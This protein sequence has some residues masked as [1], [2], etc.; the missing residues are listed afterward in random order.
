MTVCRSPSLMLLMSRPVVPVLSACAPSQQMSTLLASLSNNSKAVPVV[1]SDDF[2]SNVIVTS[3]G[4]AVKEKKYSISSPFN[5]P[6]ISSDL[7]RV[8]WSRFVDCAKAVPVAPTISS[9][10]KINNKLLFILNLLLFWKSASFF[11]AQVGNEWLRQR[12]SWWLIAIINRKT[13]AHVLFDHLII[14]A[15][16]SLET[17]SMIIVTSS[18]KSLAK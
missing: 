5:S 16:A 3:P 14:S 2:T 6:L 13:R 8:G 12:N 17:A 15:L 4:P 18:R 7:S 10:V 11:T 9:T 1:P